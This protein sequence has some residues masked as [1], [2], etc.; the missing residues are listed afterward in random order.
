MYVQ[1]P[2]SRVDMSVTRFQRMRDSLDSDLG[3]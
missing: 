1:V 3:G 2:L